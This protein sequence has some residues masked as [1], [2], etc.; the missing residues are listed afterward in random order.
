MEICHYNEL[1]MLAKLTRFLSDI[2]MA[3]VNI[4]ALMEIGLTVRSNWSWMGTSPGA[5]S[6][7]IDEKEYTS[8]YQSSNQNRESTT[9]AELPNQLIGATS[10]YFKS[11]GNSEH[12]VQL[13]GN[14]Q[15]R[16]VVNSLYKVCPV[17]L[18]TKAS[19]N[20]ATKLIEE[21]NQ[22][23]NSNMA[24]NPGRTQMFVHLRRT[25]YRPLMAAEIASK[26]RSCLY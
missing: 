13:A 12:G 11:D 19:A 21:W 25:C 10:D 16:I 26:V 24:G 22:N 1:V 6:L 14:E 15:G 3:D 7:V 20:T 8:S 18:K 17:E 4:C 5:I 9:Q 23:G 2:A